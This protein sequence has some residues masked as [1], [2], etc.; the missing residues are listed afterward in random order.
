MP[1]KY[2]RKTQR[3]NIDENVMKLALKDCLRKT[4]STREAARTYGVNRNT[5]QSRIMN[6]IKS[7]EQ[8]KYLDSDS[9]AEMDEPEN[10]KRKFQNKY[11]VKQVFT[12]HE[13]I[14][15]AEYIKR[16]SDLNYGLSYRQIQTLAYE[17]AKTIPDCKYP[18]SWDTNKFAG[19]LN[20][21]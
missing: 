13:E 9:G 10:T 3:A 20:C 12:T 1:R 18:V 15:F 6:I 8:N 4:C 19:M 16:S 17:Y 11:T 7:N 14:D 21:F 2:I 5:L